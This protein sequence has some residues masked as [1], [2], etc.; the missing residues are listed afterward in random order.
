MHQVGPVG[1]YAGFMLSEAGLPLRLVPPPAF[2][3][4]FI[5]TRI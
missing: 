4:T 5:S 3:I 1:A 2:I